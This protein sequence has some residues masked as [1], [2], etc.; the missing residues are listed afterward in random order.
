MSVISTP[1]C[2]GKTG[3][4]EERWGKNISNGKHKHS[5][6]EKDRSVRH[7]SISVDA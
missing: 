6:E 3:V 4:M 2:V 1:K 5:P 7:R